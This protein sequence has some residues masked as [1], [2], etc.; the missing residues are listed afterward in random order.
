V[1]KATPALPTSRTIHRRTFLI[2]WAVPFVLSLLLHGFTCQRSV[3]WQDS[4]MFQHRVRHA[5]Y[6]GDLGIALAHPTYIGLAKAFAAVP[7]GSFY[8]RVNVLSSVAMAITAGNLALAVLLLTRQAK[9]A[10][11]SGMILAVM[12]ISWW[13]GTIAEVYTLS[14]AGLTAELVLLILLMQRPR[15]WMLVA[16]ALVSGLGWGV[17]NFALLAMPVYLAAVFVL[18][19]RRRLPWA[20]LPIA[21]AAWLIGALPNLWLIADEAWRSGLIEAVRSA[22]FGRFEKQVLSATA[23]GRLY[24]VNMALA[25][26]SFASFVLPLAAIG[27]WRCKRWMSGGMAASLAAITVIHVL[28]FIRYPVPDQFTFLLPSA[29]MVALWAGAGLGCLLSSAAK[30]WRIAAMAAAAASIVLPPLLYAC[31]PGLAQ[32]AGVGVQRER[33]LMYRDEIRYWLVPWKHNERSAH[34][35]AHH[36]LKQA[37]RGTDQSVI[38]ADSTSFWPIEL[39]RQ[40]LNATHLHVNM[41]VGSLEEILPDRPAEALGEWLRNGQVYSVRKREHLR[42]AGRSIKVRLHK[43]ARQP[44]WRLAPADRKP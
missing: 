28:F 11:A 24:K 33:P 8:W 16:L 31:G 37:D 13:L 6:G 34:R 1:E 38:L 3:S 36:A 42:A 40:D 43:E 2:V 35:Y 10:V 30:G 9:A 18:L 44:L 15:A 21:V 19:A 41:G 12:H 25:A 22:L 29:V 4:G 32:R 26:L 7:L 27:A 5:D 17:H 14:T 20:A 39:I 23:G